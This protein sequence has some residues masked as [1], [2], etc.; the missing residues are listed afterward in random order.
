M[1]DIFRQTYKYICLMEP[2]SLA[3]QAGMKI[4]PFVPEIATNQSYEEDETFMELLKI[5]LTRIIAAFND[6]KEYHDIVMTIVEEDVITYNMMESFAQCSDVLVQSSKD[7]NCNLGT[8]EYFLD[9]NEI[10]GFVAA[11]VDKAEIE[12]VVERAFERKVV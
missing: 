5:I 3:L 9:A 12:I 6:L 1:Q 10:P 2:S 7:Y 11:A 8:Y 4:I